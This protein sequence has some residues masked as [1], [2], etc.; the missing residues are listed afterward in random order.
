MHE[1]DTGSISS[2]TPKHLFNPVIVNGLI[3]LL[4]Y[5]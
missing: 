4:E 1:S 5:F 3:Q 2:L